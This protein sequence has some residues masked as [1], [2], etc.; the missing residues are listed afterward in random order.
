MRTEGEAPLGAG[1]RPATQ[2]LRSPSFAQKPAP[3][4]PVEIS[5]AAPPEPEASEKPLAKEKKPD[6][7]RQAPPPVVPILAKG[8][9][10]KKKKQRE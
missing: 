5:R 2:G 3:A 7:E 4:K 9:K 6:G 1:R 10:A 8:A